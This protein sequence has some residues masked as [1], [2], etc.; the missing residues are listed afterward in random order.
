MAGMPA[1]PS[2]PLLKRAALVIALFGALG[3][4]ASVPS[5]TPVVSA[6]PSPADE[7]PTPVPP[8]PTATPAEGAEF[9]PPAPGCP[10]PAGPVEP[11]DVLVSVGDSPGIVATRGST[12]LATC[13]TSSASDVVPGEPPAGITAAPGDVLR[14]SLPLGWR[15]L[16]WEGFDRPA[17]G[18][19]GNVWPGVD[20][21]DRP[22]RIAVPVPVRNGDSIAGYTLWVIRDDGRVVGQI[23][24]VIQVTI[25]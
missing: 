25:T 9:V 16:H 5:A 24:I 4:N 8:G 11:P 23:E 17:A 22:A 12:T 20:T 18:E 21:P 15:F 3:C 7:E 10:S 2:S 13:T 6:S 14:L 19:G 1:A